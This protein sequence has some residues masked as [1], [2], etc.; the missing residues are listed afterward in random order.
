MEEEHYGDSKQ[1]REIMLI[2]RKKMRENGLAPNEK[3]VK[4]KE[5][6]ACEKYPENFRDRYGEVIAVDKGHYK[7]DGW[8]YNVDEYED[9]DWTIKSGKNV[10]ICI[11]MSLI[12]IYTFNK[13]NRMWTEL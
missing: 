5:Y 1:A 7:E 12:I 11:T 9:E 6:T 10:H 8:S 2:I 13:K 3:L 4:D